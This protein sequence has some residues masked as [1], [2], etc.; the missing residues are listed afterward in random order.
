MRIISGKSLRK[1]LAKG[2]SGYDLDFVGY[3]HKGKY[4]FFNFMH[5][6]K[7]DIRNYLESILKTANDD[8]VIDE[9]IQNAFDANATKVYIILIEEKYLLVINN[10]KKFKI[11]EIKNILNIGQ[12]E[13]SKDCS[14]IGKFGIGFKL[15]HRLVG[16]GTG[17]NEIMEYKGPIMFSWDNDGLKEILEKGVDDILKY[18]QDCDDK[19]N[20]QDYQFLFKFILTAFPTTPGEIVKDLKYKEDELFK[21]DEFETFLNVVRKAIGKQHINFEEGSLF[22]VEV[23]KEKMEILEKNKQNI[24]DALEYSLAIISK[25]YSKNNLEVFLFDQKITPPKNVK[26]VDI[27]GNE[28]TDDNC[29]EKT[30]LIYPVDGNKPNFYLFFPVRDERHKWNIALHSNLFKT[31]SNRTKLDNTCYPEIDYVLDRVLRVLRNNQ[32]KDL[33]KAIIQSNICD[34]NCQICEKFKVFVSKVLKI[35]PTYDCDP[36]NFDPDNLTPLNQTG[37]NPAIKDSDVNIKPP[38][39]YVWLWD[40]NGNLRANLEAWLNKTGEKYYKMHIVDILDKH[41]KLRINK[42]RINDITRVLC[43]ENYVDEINKIHNEMVQLLNTSKVQSKDIIKTFDNWNILAFQN[44]S[45][46]TD[47]LNISGYHQKINQGYIVLSKG[48]PETQEIKKLMQGF[49]IAEIPEDI[50]SKLTKLKN[51]MRHFI[52]WVNSQQRSWDISSKKEI[53]QICINISDQKISSGY[54]GGY[55]SNTIRDLKIFK[56]ANGQTKPLRELIQHSGKNWLNDWIMDK[57]EYIQVQGLVDQYL[58]T[59]EEIYDNIYVNK[60]SKFIQNSSNANDI[61]DDAFALYQKIT[62]KQPCQGFSNKYYHRKLNNNVISALKKLGI[63]VIED[64]V[65]NWINGDKQ[66]ENMLGLNQ[67]HQQLSNYLI[68]N[69]NNFTLQQSQINQN[70]FQNLIDFLSQTGDS[71]FFQHYIFEENNYQYTLIKKGNN[72]QVYLGE[73]IN[74]QLKSFLKQNHIY[75][76]E[77]QNISQYIGNIGIK[78][79]KKEI[80]EKLNITVDITYNNGNITEIYVKGSNNSPLNWENNQNNNKDAIAQLL[81]WI[82]INWNKNWKQ[83]I[84]I[85]SQNLTNYSSKQFKNRKWGNLGLDINQIIITQQ[86]L[87]T[88]N[89]SQVLA[90]F[91]GNNNLQQDINNNFFDPIELEDNEIYSQIRN[92]D[93]DHQKVF[94]LLYELENNNVSQ[95]KFT[96]NQIQKLNINSNS[97]LEIDKIKEEIRVLSNESKIPPMIIEPFLK[98]SIIIHYPVN[99]DNEKKKLMKKLYEEWKNIKP[100]KINFVCNWKNKSCECGFNDFEKY[101]YPDDLAIETEK[102]PDWLRVNNNNN[103]FK[104]FLKVLGVRVKDKNEDDEVKLRKKIKEKEV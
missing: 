90:G 45:N 24:Q 85:N 33:L 30:Y 28:K 11:Q 26:V 22:F 64:Y 102:I 46:Q 84:N 59:D 37:K 21:K 75:V 4:G 8:Q 63:N 97:G 47:F 16:S 92:P 78:K 5:G 14:K 52:D 69:N 62:N 103:D 96:N 83:K 15:I 13:K 56:S 1:I 55:T 61:L 73:N 3:E 100:G 17:I 76:I 87:N 29:D 40:D 70:E 72:E 67:Y 57:N 7:D 93:N 42:L 53:L 6:E 12:S 95:S 10:G 88:N 68:N 27:S 54:W 44:S 34:A 38:D 19:N 2:R 39:G 101:I 99:G 18:I 60:L 82:I 32:N 50:F 31:Q 81:E 71:S 41:Y 25:H 86:S 51:N 77:N 66:K 49:W 58:M 94:V 65:F 89:F 98:E 91:I 80:V 79:G 35:W 36:D 23:P 74:P 104:E 43:T 48:H 20:I 9:F